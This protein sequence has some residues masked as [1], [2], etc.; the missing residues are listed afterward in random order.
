[1]FTSRVRR[2]D[3]SAW[4]TLVGA[5]AMA[6]VMTA[7]SSGS[8][9][10]SGGDAEA[11]KEFSYLTNVENTTIKGNSRSWPPARAPTRRPHCR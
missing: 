6:L 11:P 10:G 8:S 5:G 3:R 1:M 2:H 9:T 4:P 7:C